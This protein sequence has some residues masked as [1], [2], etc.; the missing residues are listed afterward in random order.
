MSDH[1]RGWWHMTCWNG[2]SAEQQKR[3]IEVGNLPL[4]YEPEGVCLNGAEVEVTTTWDWAP[5]PRFYCL[6][7]ATEFLIQLPARRHHDHALT[8]TPVSP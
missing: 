1:R 3:L 4:G 7:C 6:P 8:D 5:G 2:L